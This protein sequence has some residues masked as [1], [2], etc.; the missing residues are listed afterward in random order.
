ML[1]HMRTNKLMHYIANLVLISVPAISLILSMGKNP[2][3]T[4]V[5]FPAPETKKKIKKMASSAQK[6]SHLRTA[7]NCKAGH[8]D[9]T[10]NN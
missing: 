1:S 8:F 9:S 3:F 10:G 2:E 5:V 4:G 6:V 7:S